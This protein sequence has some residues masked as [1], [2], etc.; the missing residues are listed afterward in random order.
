L[1]KFRTQT[2]PNKKI[3]NGVSFK[4]PKIISFEA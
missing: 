1:K 2:Q 4:Y 3:C